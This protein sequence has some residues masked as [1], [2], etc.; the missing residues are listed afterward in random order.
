LLRR[1]RSRKRRTRVGRSFPRDPD[2]AA[3]VTQISSNRP[4]CPRP[5]TRAS[6][7]AQHLRPDAARTAAAGQRTLPSNQSR[8]PARTARTARRVSGSWRGQRTVH[9]PSRPARD[10]PMDR[11]GRLATQSGQRLYRRLGTKCPSCGQWRFVGRS[12]QSHAQPTLDLLTS[13]LLLLLD[14]GLSSHACP[15]FSATSNLV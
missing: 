5:A 11:I 12:P 1:T 2:G 8:R 9:G 10:R 7:R 14:L 3:V 15:H 6:G 4:I 13:Y